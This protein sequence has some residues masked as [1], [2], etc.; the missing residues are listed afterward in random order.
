MPCSI[1]SRP[2]WTCT[3]CIRASCEACVPRVARSCAMRKSPAG[4]RGWPCGGSLRASIRSRRRSWSTQP[5]RGG[6]GGA[7]R[8]HRSDRARAEAAHRIH[9]R[10]TAGVDASRWPAVIGADESFYFKPDAGCCWARRRTRIR[11]SPTTYGRKRRRGD[12]H[13]AHRAGHEP[14]RSPPGI[15]VGR[16]ALVRGGRGSGGRFRPRCTRFLLVR[17]P[18]R[19]RHPDLAGHGRGMRGAGPGPRAAASIAAFG[20]T[21]AMLSPQTAAGAPVIC[22]R[23]QGDRA[24]RL[25]ALAQALIADAQELHGRTRASSPA[26]G[27]APDR[28]CLRHGG[29]RAESR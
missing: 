8:G 10:A 16:A 27:R 29:P 24:S 7:A 9:L 26:I 13:L 28:T 20:V 2:T 11:W 6:R 17:R 15:H 5:G 1:R 18:G 4:A 3:R 12:R 14:A 21:E 25:R 19:L 22:A 23:R